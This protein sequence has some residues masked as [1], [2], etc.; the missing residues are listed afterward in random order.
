ARFDGVS[1]WKALSHI[2][3]LFGWH[4]WENNL[5]K[6]VTIGPAGTASGLL[7]RNV[8]QAMSTSA[9]GLALVPL[10]GIRILDEQAELWN[11]IIPLGGGE[12]VNVLTLQHSTRTSPYT[13]K[14]ATGPDG[15]TYWYLE[16]SASVTAHGARTKVLSFKDAVPLAN[17]DAEI[18]NAAN[19]LYD[20][21]AAWLGWHSTVPESYEVQIANLKHIVGGTPQIWPGA[22]VRLVYRGIEIGRA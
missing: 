19:T 12:G 20:M 17:S 16:D 1:I 15:R 8:E 11:R 4:V 18:T 6:T 2:A 21:A 13:I 10:T 9:D 14:S 3:N 5:T 22:T 7:I